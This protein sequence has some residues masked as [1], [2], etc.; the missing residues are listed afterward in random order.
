MIL[1]SLVNY[2]KTD[3]LMKSGGGKLQEQNEIN[4]K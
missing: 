4:K 1:L 3:N 2:K